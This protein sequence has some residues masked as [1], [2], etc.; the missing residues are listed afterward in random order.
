VVDKALADSELAAEYLVLE[1]TESVL[2]EIDDNLTQLLKAFQERNIDLSIDDFGTGYSSLSYLAELLVQHIKIDRK[3][4]HAIDDISDGVI[5]S[6]ALE[7]VKATI[8]LGHSLQKS[9]TAE[10]IE[11]EEQ[12]MSLID[13]GCDYAQGFYISKPL[14]PGKAEAFLGTRTVL[15]ECDS[16]FERSSMLAVYQKALK[17]RKERRRD[18]FK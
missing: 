13:F 3:F 8:S 4:I 7:I 18:M 10:G 16:K 9:V 17:A 6:D 12:L 1:L 15:S 2:I 5:N 11:T 14:L